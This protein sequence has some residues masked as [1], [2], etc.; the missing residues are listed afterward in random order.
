MMKTS[1]KVIS[2]AMV[3]VMAISGVSF[4]ET[5]AAQK[6]SIY[7][8][9][10]GEKGVYCECIDEALQACY[11]KGGTI[12]IEADQHLNF[13]EQIKYGYINKYTTLVVNEDAT[14]TIGKNGLRMDGV[15]QILGTVD[16]LHSEGILY[17][18]GKVEQISEGKL[19]RKPYQIDTKKESI[20]LDAK[21]IVYGQ[22]L[23]EA[24]IAE[25][26]I[27]W[28]SSIEGS[29]Q[30][31][32]PEQKPQAGTNCHDLVFK[33]KYYMTYEEQ[34][35][36][37][38]GRVKV[39]QT[40]PVLEKAETVTLHAGEDLLAVHPDI[41]FVCPVTG[42][43]VSGEFSFS[44]AGQIDGKIGIHKVQGTF[45]PQDSNYAS[46]TAYIPVEIQVVKPQ[47]LT[48]P[49]VRNQGIYGQSLEEIHL[50]AGKC[51]NPYTGQTLAGTWEW[52]DASERLQLGK[53]V[54]EVLFLPQEEGYETVRLD[55]EVVTLPRVMGEFTWP[56]CSDLTYGDRLADASLSF[57]KNDYGT[58]CWENPNLCPA[59]K[60]NGVR[61]VFRPANTDTYDWSRLAGYD[62]SNHTV[63]ATIPIRVKPLFGELPE[64]QATEITEGTAVSGSAL[65]L[66][67]ERGKAEWKEPEQL[68]NE[69]G[70]YEA[71]FTPQDSDNYD[72]SNY[73][74]DEQGRILV[75]VY[76]KVKRK[77]VDKTG[78]FGE[79]GEPEPVRKP[80]AVLDEGKQY[81]T[82]QQVSQ[83]DWETGSSRTTFVITQMIS[84]ASKIRTVIVKKTKF[85]KCRKK[86]RCIQLCWK[87]VKGA[88]YQLQYSTNRKWKKSKKRNI[89]KNTATI[90]NIKK[91]KKYY[92]RIRCVRRLDGRTYYSKWRSRKVLG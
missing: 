12:S 7:Y 47:I 43:K 58:F 2:F 66:L 67:P 71:Y 36:E 6:G 34:I 79:S 75:P 78:P 4:Q 32:H 56:V 76:V 8:T 22:Q 26:Q 41:S 82:K 87:K 52:K 77:P 13:P 42:E 5:K 24:V 55:M 35:F 11:Q 18:D 69:S 17:G 90:R 49:L 33:P 23:S 48:E 73:Y 44:Q 1:K 88:A 38:S 51:V 30:F 84:K 40:I 60:N 62:S 83:T 37:Q 25:D 20:C 86:K 45:V 39:K 59:V 28:R 21:E 9:P 92:I 85:V 80:A 64:I 89:R 27:R 63:T 70:M 14:V 72:W 3:L 91:N 53:G 15:L 74:P 29:W 57:E 16:L 81:Q 65:S 61:V 50:V 68:V 31:L 54:Y 10:K 46:V 19:L